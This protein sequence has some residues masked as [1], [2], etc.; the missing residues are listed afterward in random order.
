MVE[1][2]ARI[3]IK[4][5]GASG[6]AAAIKK[7]DT[8]MASL[9]KSAETVV[10]TLRGFGLVIGVEGVRRA[11]AAAD[12]YK[13]L[14]ARIKGI[15]AETGDYIK[16]SEDLR[17]VSR[18]TGSQLETT[19]SVFQSLARSSKEL[20][21]TNTQMI[22]LT[23][24]VQQLGVIGGTSTA[25]MA[26]G[27]RQFSQAMAGGVVRAEEFNSIVDSLPEVANAIAKG[28][29]VG[30][31]ELR[32]MVVSGR[33]LSKDVF[34]VLLEQ[35][36]EI[37]ERFKQMPVTAERGWNAFEQSLTRILSKLDQASGITDFIG[38]GLQGWANYLDPSPLNRFNALLRE[39]QQLEA[40]PNKTTEQYNRLIDIR[41]ELRDLQAANIAA[42]QKEQ[43]QA[44]QGAKLTIAQ[45]LAAQDA[46]A[47]VKS[48]NNAYDK[49]I[50]S[51]RAGQASAAA[52]P[53]K[54]PE[55]STVL[56][57]NALRDKAQDALEK[58]DTKAAENFI[59]QAQAV[60]DYL[61]ETGQVTKN[62]YQTQADFLLK[63]AEAGRAILNKEQPK[64]ALGIDE[65]AS[66]QAQAAYLEL[67]RQFWAQN[68]AYQPV[69]PVFGESGTMEIGSG[70]QLAA[71]RLQAYPGFYA[72]EYAVGGLLRGPGTGTSDSILARVSNKE[73][74]VNAKQ[75]ARFLPLLEAINSG[76]LRLPRF[77]TGGPVS[78]NPT[79]SYRFD[80]NG[81]S[82]SGTG[83]A[84]EVTAF[85]SELR[86]EVLRR[87]R[88]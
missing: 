80:L 42:T 11:L 60:N 27:L 43:Q 70:E 49:L 16:V 64:I 78:A 54:A 84:A 3:L 65:E 14:E 47:A 25:A 76:R 59:K 88:R 40:I 87:G 68:P 4:A 28:L 35:A 51:L 38:R 71:P 83:A 20:G 9:G 2:V 81:R 61:L 48:L 72:P 7:L 18:L 10:N 1:S 46:E 67:S 73:Y 22:T 19:V 21:A 58:G 57:I 24:L 12:S 53:Q 77:A 86:R 34:Q 85:A 79:A 37:D 32:K 45:K 75:T 29:G 13:T 82:I 31:G 74:I 50:A 55:K 8:S 33:L 36:G 23:R 5:D 17:D 6:A 62:Y 56:D 44:Q 30:L 15:T 26:D 63:L 69:Y 39:R 66:A 52:G 41:R